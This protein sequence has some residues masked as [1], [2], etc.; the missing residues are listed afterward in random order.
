MTVS[1][2]M[3]SWDNQH[4]G[5]RRNQRLLY[6]LCVCVCVCVCVCWHI[7]E[8]VESY[9]ITRFIVQTV[10]EYFKTVNEYCT[11]DVTQNPQVLGTSQ[12]I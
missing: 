6:V 10:N 1:E 3:Q 12:S 7:G 8:P 4:K 9:L 11:S 2:F 5:M